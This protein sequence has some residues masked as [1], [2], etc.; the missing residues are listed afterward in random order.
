VIASNIRFLASA[1]LLSIAITMLASSSR[2]DTIDYTPAELATLRSLWIG[3][4]GPVPDDPSNAYDTDP[5]AADLGRRIFFDTRFSANGAFACVSCHR[6]ELGFQDG[7]PVGETLGKLSRRSQPLAG[8]AHNS[9]FFW[10]GRKDSLWAQAIAPLENPLELG[11][12]REGVATLVASHYR[13]EYEALFGTTPPL[14]SSATSATD[15]AP[16]P[17]SAASPTD[18]SSL[19]SSPASATVETA[20][21]S[22]K[23]RASIPAADATRITVN[24]AKAIA[25]FVRTIQPE[26]SRFDRHVEAALRGVEPSGEAALNAAELRGLRL[27]IGRAKCVN[28]HAGPLFTNG[29]FHFSRVPQPEGVPDGGR[30][31]VL[32]TLRSDEFA[33]TGIYSD[34]APERCTALRFVTIDARDAMHAFKTPSLRGVAA[35]APYMHAGQFSTLSEVLKFYRERSTG[36]PEMGHGDLT[37]AELGDLEAFFGTLNGPIS[38][39]GGR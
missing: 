20:A 38:F 29:E 30:G 6:P 31:A 28:C 7:K 32:A 19:P 5:R 36:I 18:A 10:D 8:V 15:A 24:V 12:T 25:A 13:V 2:A 3:S 11:L 17:S 4:L 21:P 14:P 16:L 37:D 35:R 27:F 33:C 26:A 9:W 23:A 34:A 22:P 1:A 39:L